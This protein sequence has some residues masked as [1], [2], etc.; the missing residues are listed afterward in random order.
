MNLRDRFMYAQMMS[1]NYE[2]CQM[3]WESGVTML[4]MEAN[5]VREEIATLQFMIAHADTPA[6]KR[7][8]LEQMSALLREQRRVREC[9]TSHSIKR[10]KFDPVDVIQGTVIDITNKDDTSAI[11][12]A[13]HV[14]KTRPLRASPTTDDHT[15]RSEDV[16]NQVTA[17]APD[18][19]TYSI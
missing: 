8:Y 14:R 2:Q 11:T 9:V 13:R 1:I 19:R 6:S 3:E 17:T 12:P 7:E 10:P 4:G 16:T 18:S 5:A 15:I